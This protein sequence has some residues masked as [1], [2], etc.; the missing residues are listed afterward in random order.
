MG[1]GADVSLG[2]SDVV[3]LDDDLHGLLNAVKISRQ[4]LLHIKQNLGFS[5]VYNAIFVPV[6]M[7]GAI[8]PLFAALAMSASSIIVVLNSLRIKM[9]FK[10]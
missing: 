5:L 9:K 1:H 4:T 3:L 6:A 2:K 10:G 8:I 7:I